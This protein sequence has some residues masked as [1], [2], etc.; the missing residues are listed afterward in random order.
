MSENEHYLVER[1]RERLLFRSMRRLTLESP[2]LE[3]KEGELVR[4]A[5]RGVPGSSGTRARTGVT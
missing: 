3:E 2:S 5:F 4:R 1:E